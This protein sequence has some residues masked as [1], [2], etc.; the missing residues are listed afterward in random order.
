[1]TFCAVA[2]TDA[3]SSTSGRTHLSQS[4]GRHGHWLGCRTPNMRLRTSSP[5]VIVREPAAVASVRPSMNCEAR[6]GPLAAPRRRWRA[7]SAEC[8]AVCAPCHLSR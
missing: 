8:S 7:N 1:M 3:R 4:F 5:P 2:Q 6:M